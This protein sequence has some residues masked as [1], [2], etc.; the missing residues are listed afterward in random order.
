MD[1]PAW[2]EYLFG[3][4]YQPGVE[5]I[6]FSGMQC[7]YC[8]NVEIIMEDEF[9]LRDPDKEFR[10]RGWAIDGYGEEVFPPCHAV[11]IDDPENMI[12]AS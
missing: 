10:R 6:P 11:Y 7:H 1:E 3:E 12:E 5:V 2:R 8:D 4:E 9:G